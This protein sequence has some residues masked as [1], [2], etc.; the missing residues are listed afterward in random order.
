MEEYI[1]LTYLSDIINHIIDKYNLYEYIKVI[2]YQDEFASKFNLLG[3]YSPYDKNLVI[4]IP[5]IVHNCKMKKKYLLYGKNK[6]KEDILIEV[7]KITYHEVAHAYQ[8]KMAVDS[9]SIISDILD[10][11]YMNM[12]LNFNKYLECSSIYPHEHMA[13]VVALMILQDNKNIYKMMLSDYAYITDPITDKEYI[14]SP[15]EK[16][17]V[18]NKKDKDISNIDEEYRLM[19]GLPVSVNTYRKYKRM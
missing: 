15:Y 3:S 2:K 12:I 5:F 16:Y 19:L 10:N 6:L 17:I 14:L 7:L 1:D 11:S 13:N 8:V 4:N 9:P 18:N